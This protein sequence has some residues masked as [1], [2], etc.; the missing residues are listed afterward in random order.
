[1]TS[2]ESCGAADGAISLFVKV[3]NCP[4]G[5]CGIVSS[6]KHSNSASVIFVQDTALE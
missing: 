2:P 5:P 4:I 1:M 6:S 3:F